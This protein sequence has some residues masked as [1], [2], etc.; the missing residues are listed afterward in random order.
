MTMSGVLATAG[1]VTF[2]GTADGW[3][4]AVDARSGKVL[5][6][7]MLGSGIIGQPMTFM[8]PDR[9]QYVAIAA[10]VGGAATVRADVI[11]LRP[12]GFPAGGNTLYV[13]SL[14]G[15]SMIGEPGQSTRGT[16]T[17]GTPSQTGRIEP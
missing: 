13:F 6:S 14:G 2:Y 1:D 4:R 10:G 17:T 3:F 7:Q 15:D 11:A 8:G 16:S 5:W 12:A 9:R